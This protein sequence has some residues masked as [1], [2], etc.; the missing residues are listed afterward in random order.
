MFR[1]IQEGEFQVSHGRNTRNRGMA[2]PSFHRLSSCQHA[3][4]FVGPHMWN[5]L[6]QYLKEIEEENTFKRSIKIYL[7]NQY[8]ES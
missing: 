4:S 3:F 2:V 6:P 8:A 1:L 5:D 7:I